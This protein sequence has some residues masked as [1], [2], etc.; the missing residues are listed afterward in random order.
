MPCLALKHHHLLS[1][2]CLRSI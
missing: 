1:F 2:V